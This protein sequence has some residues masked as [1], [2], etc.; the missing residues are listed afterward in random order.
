MRDKR[1]LVTGG[2][3]LLGSYFVRHALESG[4]SHVSIVDL[5]TYA[6]DR[7]RLS[8]IETDSRYSFVQADFAAPKAI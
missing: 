2:A 8:D 6:G 4:A 5:L 1:D 7:G 3:G